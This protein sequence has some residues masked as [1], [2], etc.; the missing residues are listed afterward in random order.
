MSPRALIRQ[1][2][3]AVLCLA[4]LAWAGFA[5]AQADPFA[6]HSRTGDGGSPGTAGIPTGGEAF[7]IDLYVQPA[8][9]P[10][11]VQ[12]G[13]EATPGLTLLSFDPVGDEYFMGAPGAEILFNDAPSGNIILRA[14]VQTPWSLASLAE[15]ATAPIAPVPIGK[16]TLSGGGFTSRVSVSASFTSE[17]LGYDAT[18]CDFCVQDLPASTL[19]EGQF[20][21]E[22][23]SVALL[24]LG[25]VGLRLTR[26][27]LFE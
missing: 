17:L 6:Y 23:A 19:A 20:V 3:A 15:L 1:L 14:T 7:E 2:S 8:V 5:M 22:P 10:L 13:V 26:E 21:P 12:I 18:S 27:R 9:V 4:T 16:L 24:L 25:L 11:T